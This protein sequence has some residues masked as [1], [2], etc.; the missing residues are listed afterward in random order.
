MTILMQSLVELGKFHVD[1]L[2][3]LMRSPVLFD[4]IFGNVSFDVEECEMVDRLG[5][6]SL[7]TIIRENV[8]A[9]SIRATSQH[10]NVYSS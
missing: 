8:A 10:T 2:N 6:I 1:M 7:S 3:S 4:M 9:T 5:M